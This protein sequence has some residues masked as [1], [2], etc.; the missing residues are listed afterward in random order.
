MDNTN[1]LSR[2]AQSMSTTESKKSNIDQ[3]LGASDE[4]MLLLDTSGSM[5]SPIDMNEPK[6][7]IDGLREAVVEIK[8]SGSCPMI[9]F[10]GPYGSEVRFVDDVPNPSG[11]TPM[12]QAI[13]M[14]KTY[15]AT[16]IVIIS[17]GMPDH[18]PTTL[19]AARNFG[20]RID[21][22][23]IGTANDYEDGKSFL[24]QLAAMSGGKTS[25]ADFKQL[26][27]KVIAFLAGDVEERAPIQG[28]GF[29]SESTGDCLVDEVVDAD[30]D[31]E[32]EDNDADA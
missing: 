18:R 28:A 5:A 3:F 15:G 25:L 4:V 19:E 31:D 30:D 29:T 27:G 23:F 22:V 17:D 21:V 6:S 2:L 7:R 12:S 9:A 8:Q 16:R 32:D 1:A 10:G 20:G 13:D 24:E 11:G 14:A 26:A